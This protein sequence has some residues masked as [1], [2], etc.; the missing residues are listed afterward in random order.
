[1]DAVYVVVVALCRPLKPQLIY[2]IDFLKMHI[3]LEQCSV[4]VVG[5]KA[6]MIEQKQ[7]LPARG[8]ELCEIAREHNLQPPVIL[9][10]HVLINVSALKKAISKS[11][12]NILRASSRDIPSSYLLFLE[13]LRVSRDLVVKSKQFQIQ[14]LL[15]FNDLGEI[16]FDQNSG[17]NLPFPS[18]LCSHQI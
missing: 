13:T 5:S 2:W 10:S 14:V 1:M 6:D 4:I 16:A 3:D 9:S 15:F 18:R 7:E 12:Q 17:K 11:A 8:K